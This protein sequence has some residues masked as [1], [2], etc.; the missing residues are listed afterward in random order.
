MD[1]RFEKLW[2][3]LISDFVGL[4]LLAGFAGFFSAFFSSYFVR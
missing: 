2:E 4:V 3:P 1:E